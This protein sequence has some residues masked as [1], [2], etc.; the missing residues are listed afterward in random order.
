MTPEFQERFTM[1]DKAVKEKHPEITVI[2]TV[3]PFQNGEDFDKGWKL[4]NELKL[5]VVDE[6]YYLDPGWFLGHQRRYDTYARNSTK[7]YLGEYA[8]WGN[9]MMNALAE[10]A[11]MTALERNGDV[12]IMASYAPMLA[13]KN[14]T[15]WRIDMIFFDNVNIYLTP[16]F[17]V[18][19]MFMTNQGDR[20]FDNIIS[21]DDQDTTLAASCVQDSKT[22]DIILKLVN[23]GNQSK[24]MKIN[25]RRFMKINPAAERIVLTG[26][27]DA[28]NTFENPHN[29]VPEQ[30][31]IKVK[32]NF[33][34]QTPA[35]SV[36]V[37][38]IRTKNQD[39]EN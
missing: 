6:H 28:E 10:A 19:K 36:T 14:F 1:I 4:A 39:S 37:I 26:P 9:K 33:D 17:Y 15:Q 5:P 12:V 29:V 23:A 35:M 25:L 24:T 38:R 13:K 34:Y 3:G 8:S 2:G 7:V 21:K 16:N 20:Y 22:G 11:Y 27:A 31:A 18:Q 30:S 32:K